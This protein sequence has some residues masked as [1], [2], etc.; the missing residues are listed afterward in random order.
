MHALIFCNKA[1][2]E[3]SVAIVEETSSKKF[4]LLKGPKQG[5]GK[6]AKKRK[7]DSNVSI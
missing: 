1:L 5:S 6:K 3:S 2:S 4:F 7:Y